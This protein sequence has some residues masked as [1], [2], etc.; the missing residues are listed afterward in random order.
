MIGIVVH[1]LAVGIGLMIL[2]WIVDYPRR[3]DRREI[4]TWWRE[5]RD[6]ERMTKLRQAWCAGFL[7]LLDE[8]EDAFVAR[9]DRWMASVFRDDEETGAR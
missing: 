9:F 7:R 5:Y 3:R 6:H 4:E 2:A 8:S 1:A